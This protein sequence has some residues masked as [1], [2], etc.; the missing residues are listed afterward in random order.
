MPIT[1]DDF[2]ALLAERSEGLEGPPDRVALVRR[3]IDRRRRRARAAAVASV[4]LLVGAVGVGLGLAGSGGHEPPVAQRTSPSPSLSPP[5]PAY[6][7]GGKLLAGATLRSPTQRSASFRFTP[8]NWQFELRVSPTDWPPPFMTV[9]TVNGQDAV[10]T[11]PGSAAPVTL[12]GNLPP[13]A[14]QGFWSQF[15]VRLGQPSTVTVLLRSRGSQTGETSPPPGYRPPGEVSVGAYQR[16]PYA[17]YPFP[18]PP[19][20]LLPL[21]PVKAGPGTRSLDA[22]QVGAN[23]RWTITVPAGS[24]LE[25]TVSTVA[26]GRIRV[27]VDGRLADTE[28][29]WDYERGG[30]GVGSTADYAAGATPQQRTVEVTVI[31]DRFPVPGWLVVATGSP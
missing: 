7:D 12:I 25:I 10:E 26:P 9:V 24:E 18:S 29:S 5:L 28:E 6:A 3:R 17:Q 30:G 16:V 27:L 22:R 31:A 1:E 20:T 14:R 4:A 13:R 11:L 19:P 15:G 23:G 21:P 8:T 2:R